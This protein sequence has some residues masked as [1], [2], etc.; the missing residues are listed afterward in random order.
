MTDV[1]KKPSVAK[2]EL[3][4]E[5]VQE[6][7]EGEAEAAAGGR[8]KRTALPPL[9]GCSPGTVKCPMDTGRCPAGTGADCSPSVNCPS[10][11]YMRCAA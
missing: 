3:S 7:T 4:K 10:R 1:R 11:P 9:G 2:L 8:K 6:L 5:T